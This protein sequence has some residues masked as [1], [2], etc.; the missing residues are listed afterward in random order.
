MTRRIKIALLAVLL[1]CTT[2]LQTPLA[3]KK[4]QAKGA[5]LIDDAALRN[6]DARAGEWIT[7]GRNYSEARFSPLKQIDSAN[8]DPKRRYRIPTEKER[9]L[10]TLSEVQ[11]YIKKRR[12][13]KPVLEAIVI[14]WYNNSP[15][16]ETDW[17]ANLKRWA[18]VLT[19][20]KTDK[21]INVSTTRVKKDA[22]I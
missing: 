19:I 11:D 7:H 10:R 15:S 18:S 2:F 20:E 13:E 8:F 22:P 17:I 4:P 1:C 21:Y 9:R 6:A 12:E 16:D 14:L 3:Q 5:R